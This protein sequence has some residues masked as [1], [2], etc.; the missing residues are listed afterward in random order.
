MKV[1]KQISLIIIEQKIDIG[2]GLDV[3][4]KK[5]VLT[6]QTYEGALE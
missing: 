5:F 2:T 1:N 4:E 6:Y 3:G